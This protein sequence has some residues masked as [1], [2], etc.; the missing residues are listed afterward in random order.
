[1]LP[2]FT[3]GLSFAGPF[4]FVGL[5]Q[6]REHLF[7]GLPLTGEDAERTCGVWVVDIRS[8]EIVAFLRFEGSVRET[9]EVLVMPGI[10]CPEI[11]EIGAD[12]LDGAFVL[13]TEALAEVPE[14]MRSS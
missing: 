7:D 1:M 14:A 10:R 5:S 12:I 6:V 13:P 11:A 2:G 9:F 3:R 8:G 4:A